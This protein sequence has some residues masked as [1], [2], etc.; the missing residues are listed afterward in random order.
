MSHWWISMEMFPETEA[1]VLAPA[2]QTLS[3]GAMEI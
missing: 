1:G 2:L 3:A